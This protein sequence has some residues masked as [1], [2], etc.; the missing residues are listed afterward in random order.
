MNWKDKESRFNWRITYRAARSGVG[1]E[2][3]RSHP[4]LS[5]LFLR[6]M[7]ARRELRTIGRF[8]DQSLRMV[9]QILKEKWS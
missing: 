7:Q 2:Y 8:E 6:A 5:T 4:E 3:V 1:L 9:R